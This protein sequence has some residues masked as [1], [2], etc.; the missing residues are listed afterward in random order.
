MAHKTVPI[1]PV[2][3]ILTHYYFRFIKFTFNFAFVSAILR[4]PLSNVSGNTVFGGFGDNQNRDRPARI[5][6]MNRIPPVSDYFC[7]GGGFLR[8]CRRRTK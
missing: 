3:G 7:R 4:Q 2:S 8:R 1:A 6:G 5:F